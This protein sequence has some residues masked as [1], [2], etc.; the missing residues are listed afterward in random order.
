MERRDEGM[1]QG[2]TDNERLTFLRIVRQ[3]AKH[4]PWGNPAKQTPE[5]W[6]RWGRA[7]TALFSLERRLLGE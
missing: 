4:C 2:M 1:G 7:Y 5:N 6:E 3:L